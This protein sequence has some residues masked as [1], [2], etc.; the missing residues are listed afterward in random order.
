[1]VIRQQ[2]SLLSLGLLCGVLLASCQAPAQAQPLRSNAQAALTRYDI[3]AQPWSN[4]FYQLDCLAGQGH[5][6]ESTFKA[7]W[8]SLGWTFED[9]AR[10]KTWQTLKNRYSRQIQFNGSS[11]EVLPLPANFDGIVLWDKIR[12]AVFNATDRQTLALNLA[13]VMQPA[14]A[15]I[16][17]GLLTAYETRFFGWWSRSGQK[18]AETGAT[19]FAQQLS[20][21]ALPNLLSQA[22]AFYQARLSEQSVLGF[23][24]MARPNLGERNLSGEQVDNQ[25]VIEVLENGTANL[26][27]TIHELCHYFYD[28]MSPAEEAQLMRLFATENSPEAIAV[29]NL[30]NEAVATA[31]GNGLVNRQTLSPEAFNKLLSTPR[32]F[33]ND[34]FIDPLAKAIYLRVEQALKN[35]EHVN[36]SSFV[37]DVLAL[38]KTAPGLNLRSPVPLLRTAAAAYEGSEMAAVFGQLQNR[39]RIGRAWGANALDERAR[40][41]YTN[42]AALS[43]VMLVKNDQ[44]DKLRD[45]TNILGETAVNDIISQAQTGKSFVYGVRRN[46]SAWIFVLVAPEATAFSTQIDRLVATRDIFTGLLP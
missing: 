37:K 41:T 43:G 7:L 33:Y 10:I 16:L 30:L 27:V 15:E 3:R 28:R 22:S 40:G 17:T 36:S 32:G 31:I 14:D 13:T 42:F 9:E 4:L 21:P 44:R 29:Y 2:L 20:Q 23:N 34:A 46:P 19:G 8:Q 26:D 12:L 5:C 35:G 1:M 39:M 24:F 25:S 38:A 6:S 45:W 11:P 18:L